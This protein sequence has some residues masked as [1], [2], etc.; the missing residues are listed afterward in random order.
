MIQEGSDIKAEVTLPEVGT[1]TIDGIVLRSA[2]G[3]GATIIKF[4]DG[5]AHQDTL[6]QL[7]FA[8]QIANRQAMMEWES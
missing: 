6:R 2:E 4:E 7:V 5:H 3:R 8:R 1:L